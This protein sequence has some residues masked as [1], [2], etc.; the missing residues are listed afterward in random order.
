MLGSSTFMLRKK[1]IL[2]K[3]KDCEAVSEES[4]KTLEEAGVF[5]PNA[6]P[7]VTEDLVKQKKLVKT[8]AEKYYLNNKIVKLQFS[9]KV[10]LKYA[11]GFGGFWDGLKSSFQFYYSINKF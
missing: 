8:K 3:F 1:M 5:N 2:K 9:K 7:K 11:T 6:F 10:E 4:A